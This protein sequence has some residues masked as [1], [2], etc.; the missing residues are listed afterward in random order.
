M[1]RTDTKDLPD[2]KKYLKNFR[3][4]YQADESK[5]TNQKTIIEPVSINGKNILNISMN[6]GHQ[7]S[8][9][10]VRCMR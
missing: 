1:V 4:K 7:N 9:R 3:L 6:T 8:G 5:R 2:I 10:P